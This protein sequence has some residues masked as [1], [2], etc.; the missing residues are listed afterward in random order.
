MKII[1]IGATGTIGKAVVEALK[2]QHDVIP[3][4]RSSGEHRVDITSKASLERAFAAI[5]EVDA[6]VCAAGSAVFKPLDQ[7]SDDDFR[8]CL[9]DKLMGQV[10]VVRTG[11]RYLRPGGSV[12][13]TS[14]V[15]AQEPTVGGAAISM[16]NGGLE[17]FVRGAAFELKGKVRVNA[18]SPPW[19]T[20]TLRAYKMD[21]SM[22]IPAARVAKAYVHSVEGS[23]TGAVIDARTF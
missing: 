21:E 20:E 18:V 6:I 19:V 2:A 13:I 16:V 23:E 8:T 1:V 12:T 15:L 3:V 9:D 17:G 11:L 7:L 4:S 10:N 22:G 5:G 14:G